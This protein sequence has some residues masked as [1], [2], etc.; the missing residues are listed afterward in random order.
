MADA[1]RKVA[2]VNA[3]ALMNVTPL[4]RSVRGSLF[5]PPRQ[6]GHPGG[7]DTDVTVTPDYFAVVGMHIVMG[8]GL[9]EADRGRSVVITQGL[10]RRYWGGTDPVGTS[11][12]YGDGTREIVGVVSDARDVSLEGAPVPTL[13][14]VWDDRD[15]EIATLLVRF[16]GKPGATLAA[17]R[18]AVRATDDR[19]A[20][21]MLSTVDDLLSTS[22][23]ER[24]FNTLLFAVFGAAA[25]VV[26][27]VGIYGLVS[28]L[29]VRREREMGIRL[30]LGAT[31]RHLERFVVAGTLRWI[32]GGVAAGMAGALACSQYLR[33]FVYQV[34][35]ND[36]ATL[37]ATGAGFLAVAAVASYIPARRTARI[38][39]LI[40]LRAE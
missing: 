24:N 8:R 19:A 31:G 6:V 14:H 17:I 10:A 3:V 12:R 33:P 15:P 29:V 22:A 40:A 5:V 18:Q 27:L 16:S 36:P 26:A 37:A 25:L 30:A 11:I 38:D 7:M 1:V 9:T 28:L 13:F 39:P 2:G 21:T 34:Q 23:A 4:Q 20:I 35:P 32:A